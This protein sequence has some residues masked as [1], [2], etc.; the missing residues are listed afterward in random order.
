MPI[1]TLSCKNS[2]S[3]DRLRDIAAGTHAAIGVQAALIERAAFCDFGVDA[4]WR[5]PA[6]VRSGKLVKVSAVA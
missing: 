4:H 1:A 2:D 5:R 3:P 6:E